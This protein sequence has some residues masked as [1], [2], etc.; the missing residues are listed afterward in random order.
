MTIATTVDSLSE[1]PDFDCDPFRSLAISHP[2][3]HLPQGSATELV[4]PNE[5]GMDE[6]E[7]AVSSANVGAQ[8]VHNRTR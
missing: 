3:S 7:S 4:S 8:S 2:P 6:A 1:A 5:A